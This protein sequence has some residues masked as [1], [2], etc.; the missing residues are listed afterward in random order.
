MR[1]V[2][3]KNLKVGERRDWRKIK[4]LPMNDIV[5]Q[6]RLLTQGY[7]GYGFEQYNGKYLVRF[8]K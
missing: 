7:H 1:Y 3:V 8:G 2:F 5:G 4:T 6:Q